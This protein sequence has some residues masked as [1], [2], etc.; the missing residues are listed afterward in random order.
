MGKRKGFTLVELLI[1]IGIC[2][3][4]LSFSLS[5][6]SQ[7][8]SALYL[9]AASRG[10]ASELRK[11][12]AL[13]VC[14]NQNRSWEISSFKLPGGITAFNRKTFVFSGSGFTPPGG[15]GTQ[16]LTDSFGH[17][18]RIIVSSAGRVRIE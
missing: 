11:A 1:T 13:A 15:N 10:A 7:L 5:A 12:Q 16:I 4:L 6:L 9:E 2:G 3:L 17:N 14:Q 8:R 18:K